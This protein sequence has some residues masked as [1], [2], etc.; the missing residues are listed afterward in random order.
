M[1][2]VKHSKKILKHNLD[3]EIYE[4]AIKLFENNKDLFEEYIKL[5]LW[6]NNKINLISRNVSRETLKEHV[7]HSLIPAEMGVLSNYD[8]IV[9]AGTGG[10]LPGIPLAVIYPQKKF[11][12]N[13]IV[14]KKVMAV[15]QIARDLKLQNIEVQEGSIVKADIQNPFVIVTKHAFEISNLYQMMKNKQVEKIIF[16]KGCEDAANEITEIENINSELFCF[17]FG[18]EHKF[19]FDKG[20]AIV[21]C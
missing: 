8:C 14:A 4:L 2:H 1:F 12:L 15:K 18:N 19:Y 7:I 6:W 21:N 3:L 13:D 20:I 9:D 10:G 5:L 11:I 16:Y 17:E